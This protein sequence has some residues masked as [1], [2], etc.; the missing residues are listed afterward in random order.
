MRFQLPLALLATLPTF[1]CTSSDD[2]ADAE[3][4][5][6][7]AAI[8]LENGGFTTTD[9][10]PLFGDAALYAAADIELDTAVTDPMATDPIVV[11]LRASASAEIRTVVV[12][13]GQLPA[14]PAGT[15]RDWNGEF[16]LSR[17]A[18][19]VQRQ[20]AFEDRTDRIVART[21][22][23]SI[24]FESRTTTRADGLALTVFDPT[25]RNSEPLTLTYKPAGANATIV[26]DLAAVAN[27]AVV[28]DAGGGASMVAIA[29]RLDACDDGFLRGRWRALAPHA[30]VYAG[31]VLDENGAPSGHV[32]GVYGVRR[33]GE[34]VFF[35]KFISRDGGF[36]GLLHGTFD[37]DSFDARWI[38]R[39]G[40]AGTAA[41]VYFA[42]DTL[43][44]GHFLGRW[45][46]KTCAP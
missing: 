37:D 3:I 38:I 22:R 28:V 15:A 12:L 36:R 10:P 30:G 27:G 33:N 42:G 46:E 7:E 16:R 6:V 40:D 4:D 41:G 39:G 19:I 25:P 18:M 20:I 23:A 44:A 17:G 14:D 43:R 1:A 34:P 13:W 2:P 35:G 45:A 24:E 32:R 8:E 21:D 31:L 11:E 26:F 5:D 9:E 29:R